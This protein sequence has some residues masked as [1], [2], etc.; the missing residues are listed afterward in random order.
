MRQLPVSVVA[1]VTRLTP[2]LVIFIAFFVLGERLKYFDIVSLVLALSGALMIV[3]GMQSDDESATER[4]PWLFV[5]LAANPVLIAFGEVAM[6]KM[7]KLPAATVVC[8]INYAITIWS[9]VMMWIL[10]EPY[11]FFTNFDLISWLLVST[12]GV[13]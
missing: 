9:L 4:S 6:R 1:V 12:Q 5:A 8:Y 10:S 7:R 11:D 2:T 13:I 3:L